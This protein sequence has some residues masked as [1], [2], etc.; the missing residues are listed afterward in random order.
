VSDLSD[1]KLLGLCYQRSWQ[2]RLAVF[3][4][5]KSL[6]D[7]N[8]KAEILTLETKIQLVE[9]SNSLKDH[10]FNKIY[11]GSLFRTKA[12]GLIIARNLNLEVVLDPRLDEISRGI[13]N[14]LPLNVF[15]EE[16][17]KHGFSFDYVPKD[18]ES[19]N[20]ARR[21]IFDCLNEIVDS[22]RG[23][24]AIIVTHKGVIANI[25]MSL[26]GFEYK[27]ACL[28][29]GEYI[30]L[31]LVNEKVTLDKFKNLRP[32]TKEWKFTV[33][34][35]G[36]RDTLKE[37]FLVN[38][39]SIEKID[40]TFSSL[41]EIFYKN[42]YIEAY[43]LPSLGYKVT[44]EE[45]MYILKVI[46]KFY[47]ERVIKLNKILG[48]LNKTKTS[49]PNPIK[50]APIVIDDKIWTVLE[51]RKGS[52][53]DQDGAIARYDQITENFIC[54]HKN[55]GEIN[56]IIVNYE[57][58]I[59]FRIA[60]ESID[61]IVNKIKNKT[62]NN[63]DQKVLEHLERV[64][65]LIDHN[66][67]R[68]TSEYTWKRHQL[69]HGDYKLNNLVWNTDFERIIEIIDFDMCHN[70]P[71]ALQISLSGE[72][73]FGYGSTYYFDFIRDAAKNLNVPK[74]DIIRIPEAQIAHKALNLIMFKAAYLT[75]DEK[76]E[77]LKGYLLTKINSFQE[78]IDKSKTVKEKL[79]EMSI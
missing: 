36:I 21:R 5:A 72:S 45:K 50:Y 30:V 35:T 70:G 51:T 20:N 57:D 37:I 59:N 79:I 60:R 2:M 77:K 42:G 7:Q 3:R 8:T 67:I 19:I 44:A 48:E 34:K 76:Y 39:A 28:D 53:M 23:V 11:T 75:D 12:S 68:D 78:F 46:P 71:I 25:L 61:L 56:E 64:T 69:V 43:H 15:Y 9:S 55:L 16:W 49:Y 29:C 74:E 54:L 22:N 6:T 31:D 62:V 27:E 4:H 73:L 1:D 10:N 18:G 47:L 41:M 58:L 52:F 13:F 14:S 65:Y 26:Y 32:L 40:G 17:S 38:P 33:N 63:F 24:G 66:Q